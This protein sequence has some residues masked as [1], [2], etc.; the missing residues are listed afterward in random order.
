MHVETLASGH[1]VVASEAFSR[2]VRAGNGDIKALEMEAAGMLL[3]AEKRVEGPST[4][5]IR[6]ISDHVEVAKAQ[7]EAIEAGALRRLAMRNA[8]GVFELLMEIQA[9]ERV[10][11]PAGT[12]KNVELDALESELRRRETTGEDVTELREA[13]LGMRRLLRDGFGLRVGDELADRYQL[14]ALAGTGGFASVWKAWDKTAKAMVAVKVLHR[15][16]VADRSRVE[17]F[18]NGARQMAKLEHPGVTRVLELVDARAE[19]PFFVMPY[20]AQGDLF[21]AIKEARISTPAALRALA[22][23]AEAIDHAHAHG[24]IHR[25]VKPQNI[26]IDGEGQAALGDFDLVHAIDSTHGTRTG[27]LGTFIYA[28]P[29]QL[30]DASKP[31]ARVDVYGLGMTALYCLL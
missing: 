25:D 31:D 14:F 1:A 15:Q 13:I 19:Q 7:T 10:S 27:A 4:L 24:V 20:M 23:V 9:F 18:T 5:V 29:E 26:L 3:A 12:A 22:R 21:R 30:E 17:R 6:G 16:W 8:L 28:A 11:P 2:W